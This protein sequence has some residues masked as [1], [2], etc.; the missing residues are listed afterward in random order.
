MHWRRNAGSNP[1]EMV[2]TRTSLAINA[3]G[4]VTTGIALA[5]I[6]VAKF[7]A[8]AWI[9]LVIIP[10]LF[11]LFLASKRHYDT[12][13]RQVRIPCRLDLSHN[14]P[15]VVVVPIEGWN[16]LTER[17]LRFAMRLSPD[18]IA[19]HAELPDPRDPHETQRRRVTAE[20]QQTWQTDVAAPARQAGL[21]E[22]KLEILSSPFRKVFGPL[23]GYLK[24]IQPDYPDRL[25]AVIIPELV[26][27][28]WWEWLLHNH[29]ATALKANLLL[30]RDQRVV[31]INVPWYLGG[32]P[33]MP[34]V[35]AAAPTGTGESRT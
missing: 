34:G 12:V 16:L 35:I 13:D 28:H 1:R 19:V 7:T 17:A 27:T 10:A 21:Q 29:R 15:P 33:S 5:I 14:E 24:K 4:A 18:V 6:L 11:G 8:G 23:S 30:M 22:P 32:A 31:V 9:T 25:I 2:K 3:A 20:L 26:E